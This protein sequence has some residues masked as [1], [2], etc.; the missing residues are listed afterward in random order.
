MDR[1]RRQLIDVSRLPDAVV[2]KWSSDALKEGFVPFPKRLV[3]CLSRLYPDDDDMKELAALLAIVDFKRPNASRLPSKE[4]LS[5][6]AGLSNE[7]FDAALARLE[8]KGHV[9]IEGDP[10]GLQVSHEGFLK[11]IEEMLQEA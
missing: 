4:Y 11:A 10:D 8:S 7:E 2:A 3:R 6:L 9:S 5:Y 1:F